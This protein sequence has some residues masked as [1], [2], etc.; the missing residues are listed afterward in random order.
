VSYVDPVDA[1]VLRTILYGDVFDFPMTVREIHH[2]LIHDSPLSADRIEMALQSSPWLQ[3]HLYRVNGYIC[4]AGRDE[5]IHRREAREQACRHLWPRALRYGKWL[6]RLPYIRMVGLTGALAV[7]NPAAD[8]DDLDYLLI[9]AANR[10]WLARAFAIVLVRAA[11]LWGVE[12]CPNYVMAEDALEQDCKDMFMAHEVA[13]IVPL[14][15]RQIYRRLR[16]ANGWV[17]TYLPNAASA[18]YDEGEHELGRGWALL[19]RA[20]EALLNTRL[21]DMLERWEYRRKLRRFAPE[22]ES[23]HSA[24]KL[25]EQHVKGHFQDHGHPALA[26]YADRLRRYGLMPVSVQIKEVVTR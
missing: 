6:A 21:G 17:S 20:A 7:R 12:I 13:Q 22:L 14:F 25:D 26:G 19:K 1:A 11:R 18:F 15:G 24:A 4:L 2:F 10:V 9:T 23:P 3:Q 8:D 16:D 5:L